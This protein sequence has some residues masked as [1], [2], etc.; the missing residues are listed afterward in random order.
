MS[1]IASSKIAA[2]VVTHNR[3]ALLKVCVEALRGQTRKLDEIIVVDNASNDGTHEWLAAQGDL[4]IVTQENLGSSGG[5]YTGIKIAYQRGHDWVW[6]MDDDTLPQLRAL[7]CLIACPHFGKSITG[8]LSSVVLWKDGTMHEM[9]VPS[10]SSGIKWLH[11]VLE[12]KCLEV[13]SNSFVSVLISR[14]AI[15]KVGFP[16]KEFFIWGD[17]IEYTL[18]I[19]AHFPCY[20]VLDSKV[21]HQTKENAGAGTDQTGP[22]DNRSVKIQCYYRN[23]VLI[24]LFLRISLLRRLK[25][26]GQFVIRELLHAKSAGR[27]F[28]ILRYS[29]SGVWLYWRIHKADFHQ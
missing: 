18:R 11:H 25:R 1:P 4:T 7:E 19:S 6:C 17:D 15:A 10:T 8:F 20:V 5:Q 28:A 24:T 13:Q 2:V 22:A 14:P 29:L 16:I 26:I 3:L 23:A 9:N 12:E 21:I 27:V